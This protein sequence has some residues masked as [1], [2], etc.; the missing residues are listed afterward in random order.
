MVLSILWAF[1]MG[2]LTVGAYTWRVLAVT[3][4]DVPKVLYASAISAASVFWGTAYI[5]QDDVPSYL[6][7]SAGSAAITG[8]M[9]YRNKRI[10]AEKSHELR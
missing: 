1:F 8:L 6:A 4:G 9:A 2:A 5:V 7:F 3:D 10:R